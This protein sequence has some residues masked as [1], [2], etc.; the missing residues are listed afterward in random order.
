[1]DKR[2]RPRIGQNSSQ[3]EEVLAEKKCLMFQKK[4]RIGNAATILLS[5]QEYV[6]LEEK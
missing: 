1:M 4:V 3:S 6:T 5:K 2:P